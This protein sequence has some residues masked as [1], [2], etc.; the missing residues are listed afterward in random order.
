MTTQLSLF[1]TA[2]LP[3]LVAEKWGFDLAYVDRDGNP[4]HYFYSVQDWMVGLTGCSKQ[5]ASATWVQSNYTRELNSSKLPYKTTSGRTYQMDFTD[6]EGLYR[7]A[8]ELRPLKKRPDLAKVLSDI[9]TYL[10]KAGVIVDKM[11]LLHST[12][13]LPYADKKLLQAKN[14]QGVDG[15]LFL[16]V[17]HD[18]RVARRAVTDSLKQVVYEHLNQTHYTEATNTTYGM[19]GKTAKQ[20]KEATGFKVARDAMTVEGRSLL[21]AAEA[22]IDRLLQNE[23][24]QIPFA[25][26]IEIIQQVASAYR[27]SVTQIERMIG[28]DLAT[29]KPLLQG[30]NR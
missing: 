29:N 8:Q 5:H 12:Q 3:L 21:T 4:N 19:F 2:P 18:G 6:A 27:I 20:I 26:A 14:A 17:A 1:G 10:A 24:E 15:E 9:Y 11:R 28:V 16:K 7:I 22:T 23:P 13:Q 25:R 30:A